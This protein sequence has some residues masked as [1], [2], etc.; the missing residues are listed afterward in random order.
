MIKPK[1]FLFPTIT[2]HLFRRHDKKLVIADDLAEH[3]AT[4]PI[5]KAPHNSLVLLN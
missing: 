4:I 3:P 1:T 5:K 2:T